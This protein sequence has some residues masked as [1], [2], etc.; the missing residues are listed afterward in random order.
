MFCSKV[1]FWSQ[2]MYFKGSW[3]WRVIRVCLYFIHKTESLH[4]KVSKVWYAF[5]ESGVVKIIKIL[6]YSYVEA[7][8]P[9]ELVLWPQHV[10][11]CML[12]FKSKKHP[13]MS[14]CSW[15]HCCLANLHH[16]TIMPSIKVNLQNSSPELQVSKVLCKISFKVGR[17]TLEKIWGCV[18]IQNSIDNVHF[19]HATQSQL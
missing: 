14:K 4:D 7:S 8:H 11:N 1:V 9:C 19:P 17:I 5:T 15:F 16:K 2:L 13:R 3:F 6:R 18:S 12:S 10:Y